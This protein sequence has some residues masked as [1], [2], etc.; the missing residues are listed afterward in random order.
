MNTI[1]RV[2]SYI[3]A[4]GVLFASVS[5]DVFADTLLHEAEPEPV[6]ILSEDIQLMDTQTEP[7]SFPADFPFAEYKTINIINFDGDGGTASSRFTIGGGSSSSDR[8]LTSAVRYGDIG[9]S[10]K[11]KVRGAGHRQ[12]ITG[13]VDKTKLESGKRYRI[14]AMVK[15]APESVLTT[16]TATM[17]P[18]SESSSKSQLISSDYQLYTVTSDCWTKIAFEFD[19][20]A[21][22]AGAANVFF[23]YDENAGNITP[24]TPLYYYVDN[25]TF[26]EVEYKKREY[27]FDASAD[28]PYYIKSAGELSLGVDAGENGGNTI[29]AKLLKEQSVA[30]DNILGGMKMNAGDN[31]KLY[32]R[33][34]STIDT[35]V[36]PGIIV[37]DDE[38]Q[39]G[40]VLTAKADEW[41]TAEYEFAVSE[42]LLSQAAVGKTAAK[43]TVL[44]DADIYIDSIKI[45]KFISTNPDV[46][47]KTEMINGFLNISGKLERE[48][49]G[50][51]AKV[52]IIKEGFDA[53]DFSLD[54]VITSAD[55]TIDES[56]K[57]SVD[58]PRFNSDKFIS[59]IT[60]SIAPLEVYEGGMVSRKYP[61][62]DVD[63]I[64]NTLIAFSN[65]T[66]D[67]EAIEFLKKPTN[68]QIFGYEE[69]DCYK[70]SD[71]KEWLLKYTAANRA[72]VINPDDE[73]DLSFFNNQMIFGMS[74]QVL[75]NGTAEEIKE[76]IESYAKEFGIDTLNAYTKTYAE[77][78]DKL[79]LCEALRGEYT[80]AEA[81]FDEFAKRIVKAI[82]GEAN[83]Y[84]VCFSVVYDNAKELGI[85]F[86]EYD[87]IRKS[88]VRAE[89]EKEFA[90]YVK[91]A[92]D[93]TDANDKLDDIIYDA[94]RA[95]QSSGSS[96]G[97]GSYGGGGGSSSGTVGGGNVLAGITV[98][99]EIYDVGGQEDVNESYKNRFSDIENVSWAWESINA[100]ADN[101]VI[102]GYPD[103]SFRPFGNITRAEVVKMLVSAFDMLNDDAECSFS[104]VSDGDWYKPYVA[105]LISSRLA[106]GMGDGSFG[107]G[108]EITRQ[109]LAVLAYNIAVYLDIFATENDSSS[110]FKDFSEVSSY[111]K[112]AVVCLAK[113]GVISGS[114]G[115]FS[116]LAPAT[117]AEAARIIFS[118]W[119]IKE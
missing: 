57:Y 11:I 15:L 118:L 111:A 5:A 98:E 39:P 59:D 55:I 51:Q 22:S 23:G 56:G 50:G 28:L 19:A 85:D 14:S 33:L 6:I 13:L 4:V 90:E 64:K 26:E 104:D 95:G 45:E 49:A 1:I 80:K 76:C 94:E 77:Y 107:A 18:Y 32:V 86:S 79:L 21:L 75:K 82:I 54:A 41:T 8:E 62:Q 66:T 81:L 89:I 2:L 35:E 24:D 44:S 73:Y 31:L 78:E 61:Y 72:L 46:I 34:K 70:E 42:Y 20:G 7:D 60:I 88:T 36:L 38:L 68:A 53:D 12:M 93:F 43:L 63:F 83:S 99:N 30:T 105:T 102:S 96:G 110:D 84:G 10:V 117:R 58:I 9:K 74:M 48:N 92:K 116:P 112:N 106:S 114:D 27:N 17:L 71:D 119:Q 109:D 3:L 16:A 40:A 69:L 87:D 25:Y 47:A 101:G 115:M 52:Y 113:N 91:S 67:E 65:I 37:G 108:K 29:F 103:G 97:G 100:L